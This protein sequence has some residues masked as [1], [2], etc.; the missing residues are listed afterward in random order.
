MAGRIDLAV[1]YIAPPMVGVNCRELFIEE[2]FLIAPA[3]TKLQK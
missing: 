2:L 1:A 3:G